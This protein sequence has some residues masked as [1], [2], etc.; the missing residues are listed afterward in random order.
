MPAPLDQL[1]AGLGDAVRTDEVNCENYR[2]DWARDPGAGRP[3]AVVRAR[4]AADVQTTVRWAAEFGVPVVPRGAGSGLSGGSSADD[5][6]IV[7]SMERMR[8]IEIDVSTR[9]AVV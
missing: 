5:G 6:G 3:I 9:V 8:A 7:L 2:F 1:Q 4:D